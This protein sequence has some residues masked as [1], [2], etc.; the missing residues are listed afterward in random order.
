MTFGNDR[1]SV[2]V[3]SVQSRLLGLEK[4]RRTTFFVSLQNVFLS[5]IRSRVET[6]VYA[7]F[8]VS[9]MAAITAATFP[10]PNLQRICMSFSSDSVNRFSSWV[11]T[12]SI[13]TKALVTNN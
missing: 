11:F 1:G 12:P 8:G 9:V 4:I 5:K 7:G 6:L 2:K 3:K 10:W 13:A